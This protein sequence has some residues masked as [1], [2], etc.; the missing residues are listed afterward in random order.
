M[1]NILLVV[2]FVNLFYIFFHAKPKLDS[3]IRAVYK[4]RAHKG[5]WKPDMV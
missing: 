3:Y 4:K 2:Y 1:I 5:T